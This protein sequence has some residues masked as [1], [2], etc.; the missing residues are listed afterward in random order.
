M[1][2]GL[3]YLTLTPVW[4]ERS[5]QLQPFIRGV[6]QDSFGLVALALIPVI[7]W[8]SVSAAPDDDLVQVLDSDRPR[9]MAAA[10]SG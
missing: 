3:F 6:L 4:A 10:L 7:W 9:T 5:P 2:A 8:L 1:L